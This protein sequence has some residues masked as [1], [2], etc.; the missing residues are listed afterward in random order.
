M[1]RPGQ[2]G[3]DVGWR[4]RP[5]GLRKARPSQQGHSG[6]CLEKMIGPLRKPPWTKTLF[7]PRSARAKCRARPGA[8]RDINRSDGECRGG[9]ANLPVF[10]LFDIARRRKKLPASSGRQRFHRRLERGPRSCQLGTTEF[11]SGVCP[12]PMMASGKLVL[13]PTLPSF[14]S[15]HPQGQPYT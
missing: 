8:M 7:A 4:G 6:R 2:L 11:I 5:T 1:C 13:A 10:H 14:R 15:T 9:F 3:K 12:V